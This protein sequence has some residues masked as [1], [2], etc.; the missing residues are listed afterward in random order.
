MP[1]GLREQCLW[2]LSSV[3]LWWFEVDGAV[4]QIL[5]F[6]RRVARARADV[7]VE[8][9]HSRR[10][11]PSSAAAATAKGGLGGSHAR[12]QMARSTVESGRALSRGG[13]RSLLTRPR[14]V[15]R[16]KTQNSE[17]NRKRTR[18][19]LELLLMQRGG[20]CQGAAVTARAL[21]WSSGSFGLS[22]C[23]IEIGWCERDV[24]CLAAGFERERWGSEE[25]E[26]GLFFFKGRRTLSPLSLLF[27]PHNKKSPAHPSLLDTQDSHHFD[28]LSLTARHKI[29]TKGD[30]DKMP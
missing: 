8:R 20:V 25:E 26:G 3:W 21:L 10:G 29:I 18:N 7:R 1:G 28:S 27:P 11:A 9:A 17:K 4:C 19:I 16:Q 13:S 24:E 30:D 6:V 2:L 14:A 22:R 15:T 5:S 12:T 23:W